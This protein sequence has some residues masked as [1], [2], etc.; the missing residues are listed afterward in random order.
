MFLL[1]CQQIF[2]TLNKKIV[3]LAQV[4]ELQMELVF[5]F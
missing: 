5:Y 2:K 4:G 3:V 1:K